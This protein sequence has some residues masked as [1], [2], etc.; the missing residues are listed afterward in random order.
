[1]CVQCVVNCSP[2]GAVGSLSTGVAVGIA[3]VTGT[4]GIL[5]GFLAGLIVF[6]CISKHQF[7]SSSFKP[8]PSSHQPEQQ[9]VS[10]SDP[11]Q[12]T[13]PEYEEVLEMRKNSSYGEL[14]KL[15]RRAIISQHEPQ[16][17]EPESLIEMRKNS[18]Y[19]ELKKLE[20][21]PN[22]SQY[23]PQSSEP[24]SLI[25]M[26]KNASYGELKKLE[27]RAIISQH[28]PQSS[29]PESSPQQQQQ[30]SAEYEEPVPNTSKDGKI[31]LGANA[32]YQC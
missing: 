7:K 32:A 1:M 24:E 19:G 3:A 6:Y 22:I 29:E 2:T 17:S 12:Q 20:R 31:D 10:S 4:L 18:S 26:R 9:A 16:S 23:E 15:E 8:E 13:S 27:K 5:V 11:L 14:K 21:R 30:T 28:E 25:E